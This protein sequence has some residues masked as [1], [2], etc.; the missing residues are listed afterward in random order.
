MLVIKKE[1]EIFTDCVKSC[2][3]RMYI[4]H[5]LPVFLIQTMRDGLFM[6]LWLIFQMFMTNHCILIKIEISYI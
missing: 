6:K 2:A 1:N 5:Q 4:L 3:N